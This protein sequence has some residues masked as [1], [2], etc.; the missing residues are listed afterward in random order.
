[1]RGDFQQPATA[2][3]SPQVMPAVV[4]VYDEHAARPQCT[5]RSLERCQ[6]GFRRRDHTQST[7][8]AES[9]VKGSSF[10]CIERH[11]VRLQPMDGHAGGLGIDSADPQHRRG[12][13]DADHCAAAAG[14]W[15]GR[16]PGAASEVQNTAAWLNVLFDELQIALQQGSAGERLVVPVGDARIV[17]IVPDAAAYARRQLP[18]GW[19]GHG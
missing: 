12:K 11:D 9:G 15:N 19:C 18:I 6:P 8:E 16:P 10:N 7:E 14:Q 17:Q 5:I 4:P 1:M 2:D 3:G 13:I